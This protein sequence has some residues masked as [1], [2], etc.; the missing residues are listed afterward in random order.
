MIY[1]ENKKDDDIQEPEPTRLTILDQSHAIFSS[2]RSKSVLIDPKDDGRL[3]V[4]VRTIGRGHRPKLRD[5]IRASGILQELER[6]DDLRS[7]LEE[8]V[9]EYSASGRRRHWILP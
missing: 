1:I 4:S 2:L 7:M 8:E 3:R 6:D 9:D 5:L